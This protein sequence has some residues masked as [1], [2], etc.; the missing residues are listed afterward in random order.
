M[1]LWL[2]IELTTLARICHLWAFKGPVA[3]MYITTRAIR[4][5][6]TALALVQTTRGTMYEIPTQNHKV[7]TFA[8]ANVFL[9]PVMI[10]GGL[11]IE[12]LSP[13]SVRS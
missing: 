4:F 3:K 6:C 8:F 9:L 13:R 7:P 11:F 2:G 10:G 1:L 12:S 5:T